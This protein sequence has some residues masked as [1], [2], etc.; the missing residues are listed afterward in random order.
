MP[1]KHRKHTPIVSKAQRGK[2]ASE[3]ARRR[4]GKGRRMKGITTAELEGHLEESGGKKLPQY[5][6]TKRIFG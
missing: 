4:A 5:A 1:G 6:N 2:F 3:L